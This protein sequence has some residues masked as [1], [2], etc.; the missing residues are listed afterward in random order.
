MRIA[1][2][3]D[4]HMPKRANKLPEKL[5]E[6]VRGTGL[7][8]HAGDWSTIEVYEELQT[9]APV[10]GVRGNI[11]PPELPFGEKLMIV[12]KGYRIGIVHGHVGKKKTTPDRAYEAFQ[13]QKLDL[14]V[15]GHSHIP[16][17]QYHGETLLFNPGSPTDKRFQPEFSY[18]IVTLGGTLDAEHI[19]YK[20]KD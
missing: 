8:I 4:T 3:S 9:I 17:K 13:G 6:G 7:I 19:Y 18:G 12:K 1:V 16:Y 10:I 11:D 15:F 14:I 20:R 5:V 2:I